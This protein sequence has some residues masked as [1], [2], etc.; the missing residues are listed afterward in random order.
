MLTE[1]EMCVHQKWGERDKMGILDRL[2]GKG[3]VSFYP[4][5]EELSE[6]RKLLKRKKES[7]ALA[8]EEREFKYSQSKTGR[9][10]DLVRKGARAFPKPS[11]G[12]RRRPSRRPRRR[13][14]QGKR[15][16]RKERSYFDDFDFEF[17]SF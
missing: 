5:E 7:V 11:T 13:Q 3:K 4:T 16:Q 8:K 2:R 6:R 1:L 10:I 12:P 17:P 9:A 14:K 15:K